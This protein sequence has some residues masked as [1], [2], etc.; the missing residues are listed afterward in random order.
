M[1]T[2]LPVLAVAPTR[3]LTPTPDESAA[4]FPFTRLVLVILAFVLLAF[5]ALAARAWRERHTDPR[6][7]AFRTIAKRMN[8]N[9][10]RIREIRDKADQR[11]HT[12]AIGIL[13]REYTTADRV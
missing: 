13:I 1:I 3:L 6:E 9:A 12:T 10:Q 11:P 4:G 2:I 7:L 5:L 8:L